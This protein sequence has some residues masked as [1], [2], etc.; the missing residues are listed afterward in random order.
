MPPVDRECAL[1]LKTPSPLLEDGLYFCCRGCS[2]VYR[3][4]KGKGVEPSLNEPLV[5]HAEAMGLLNDKKPVKR[6]GEELRLA[7]WIE[8]LFCPSCQHLIEHA[9]G[10]M[11]GVLSVAVDYTTDLCLVWYQP[12]YVSPDE[13]FNVVTKLGY[14]P[15]QLEKLDRK[16]WL[17]GLRWKVGLSFF[18][19]L[20]VMMASYP[21]LST[22]MDGEWRN[23]FT[24]FAFLAALPV[25]FY[26]A[27]PLLKQG[28][29]SLWHGSF[30]VEA[31][32]AVAMLSGFFLSLVNLSNGHFELYLDAATLLPAF[33][34]TGKLLENR[35]K[36]AAREQ[37]LEVSRALPM[38]ARK[39]EQW[40]PIKEIKLNDQILIL[41]GEKVVLDGEVIE[42]EAD[43]DESIVTGE[44]L[45]IPKKVGDYLLAGTRLVDGWVKLRVT[46]TV[47]GSTL[48]TMVSLIEEGLSRRVSP[49]TLLDRFIPYFLPVIFG[50][51]IVLY[52]TR[53]AIDAL[54]LLLLACPCT[55]GIALPIA[56][57]HLGAELGDRGIVVRRVEGLDLLG[58]ETDLLLDKTGTLTDGELE[59]LS[60]EVP[61]EEKGAL[62]TLVS[63]SN[64]P[65]SQSLKKYLGSVEK[66]P[67]E[68]VQE[69]GGKG[70]K[71][72]GRF[73]GSRRW[74][75]EMHFPL[76]PLQNDLELFYYAQGKVYR[77]LFRE[78]LREGIEEWIKTV[79]GPKI[80]ILSG[81]RIE[82]VEKLAKRLGIDHYRAEVTPE[83][84]R[85]AVVDIQKK[86]GKVFF[87]GDGVN[88]G[89]AL[90]MADLSLSPAGGQDLTLF[91]SD[92]IV[93]GSFD[94]MITARELGLKARKII[95]QN[96]GLSF[97]YNIAA[98][99]WAIF[100]TG[101][102]PL[103]SAFVMGISSVTV[104]W[105][106]SR[107][108]AS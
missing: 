50:I 9:L 55:I 43:V 2:F 77:F 7:F 57:A 91:V 67:L 86:G 27:W 69:V 63:F 74:F 26:A 99:L 83:E 70:M 28:V 56:R 66:T 6:E 10:K 41:R 22:H 97:S 85:Q 8:G 44:S 40:V 32:I 59:C 31:F 60:L 68:D 72:G 30:G 95:L 29:A 49:I 37:L 36:G 35:V 93:C 87:I 21:L 14:T 20:N 34:L 16:S 51:A 33:F 84:K 107:I 81:D 39:D 46:K 12:R 5:K 106:A 103:I 71:G 42:G 62:M 13:I 75:E 53:G 3:V 11:E 47:E 38:K 58:N 15:H 94:K 45:P 105:N 90:S 102:T 82:R 24:A 79:K 1:C 76:P 104:L 80:Q 48:Q 73:L 17:D 92:L 61:E 4:L 65:L 108:K 19:T 98:I 100:G 96:L 23:F 101:L 64:H 25:P 18:C 78:H 88:D 54:S 52:F 89:P